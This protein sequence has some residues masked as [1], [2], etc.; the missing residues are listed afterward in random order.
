M[1]LASPL[2]GKE[3]PAITQNLQGSGFQARCA[4]AA[5]LSTAPGLLFPQE[6]SCSVQWKWVSDSCVGS[7]ANPSSCWTAVQV[8]CSCEFSSLVNC[9]QAT[10][11]SSNTRKGK[12][13]C[14]CPGHTPALLELGAQHGHT[15]NAGQESTRCDETGAGAEALRSK[16]TGRTPMAFTKN[17]PKCVFLG[18][19]VL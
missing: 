14:H 16:V 5:A 15:W 1:Q 9:L 12:S 19:A 11:D 17:N 4:P 7:G 3:P 8:S 10:Q 13:L 18:R 6:V 2:M